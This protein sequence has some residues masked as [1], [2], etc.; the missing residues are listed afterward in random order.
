MVGRGLTLACRLCRV[1]PQEE[2][3]SAEAAQAAEAKAQADFDAQS[4]TQA[5]DSAEAIAAAASRNVEINDRCFLIN[6][7]DSPGHVDFS[8]EVSEK[9]AWTGTGPSRGSSRS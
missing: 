8:S 1:C 2:G 9:A 5:S 4:A 7:I 3:Q 6:L